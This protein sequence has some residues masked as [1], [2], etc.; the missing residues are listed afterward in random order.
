MPGSMDRL[1][2]RTTRSKESSVI[3]DEAV[4]AAARAIF[5]DPDGETW[6]LQ[7]P[8]VRE[9][10]REDARLALEAAAPHMLA[11]LA[12]NADEC[13][14]DDMDNYFIDQADVGGWLRSLTN[15][16]RSQA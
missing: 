4:E 10:C 3:S 8:A 6:A 9:R 14:A 1:H 5:G 2:P 16:Y 15:P 7:V 11:D 12:K 13:T